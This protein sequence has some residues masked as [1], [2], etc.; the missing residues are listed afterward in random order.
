MFSTGYMGLLVPP[1]VRSAPWG[2][3]THA[4]VG[5]IKFRLLS[6]GPVAEWDTRVFMEVSN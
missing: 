5:K 6:Q 3:K 1:G 4:L 2:E